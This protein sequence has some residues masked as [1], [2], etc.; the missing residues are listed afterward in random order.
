MIIMAAIAGLIF[1]SFLNVVIYRLPE[2][3]SLSKPRSYCTACKRPVAFYD[4]IPVISYLL[5]GGKCRH[6][7]VKISWRYPFIELLTA[8]C[9]A[10]LFARYGLTPQF[11]VY[12]VL[13]LFLIPISVIDFDRGLILNRLTIAGFILGVPL[14]I[15]LQVETWSQ[16]LIGAI[17]SG[18]IVL[19]IGMVGKILFKKDSM[20]MGDV[21]LLVLIGAYI[22]LDGA[23]ISLFLGILIAGIVI[24]GGMALKKLSL[25]D[26]IP[27]GPFIAVGTLVYLTVGEKII[28]WYLTYL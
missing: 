1:G 19:M 20:G 6:C 10:I 12:S 13:T 27:F 4:N 26:T 17:G 3:M 24:L 22:G 9:L 7:G 14:V 15:G 23:A 8:F 2:G 28:E 11:G 5:L 18:L 25:G 16:V 21:K